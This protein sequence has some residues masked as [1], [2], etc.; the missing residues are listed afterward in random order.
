MTGAQKNQL[1]A[2]LVSLFFALL[3][4]ELFFPDTF[5]L[6]LLPEVI[7]LLSQFFY[8]AAKCLDFSFEP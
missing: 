6:K 3:A 4:V 1:Y 2:P 5:S 8:F 7:K